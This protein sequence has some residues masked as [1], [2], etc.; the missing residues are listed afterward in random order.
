MLYKN[1]RELPI[2]IFNEISLTND[3]NLLIKENNNNYTEDQLLDK[4]I[5][6]IDEY[7]KLSGSDNAYNEKIS[8]EKNKLKLYILIA[9]RD[10]RD[11]VGIDNE[12]LKLLC[13]DF[14]FRIDKID[15]YINSILKS[16]KTQDELD[17]L[18]ID[19]KNNFEDIL[20]V[21]NENGFNI[22]R[23]IT[24]VSEYLAYIN[25]LK[26]IIKSKEKINKR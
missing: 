8:Y 25:R 15:L 18:N 2:H 24:P 6:I 10:L 9:V 5:D 17:K 22:N 1:C 11:T 3:L 13:K 26:E 23:F 4:W 7:N 16:L 19:K 20:A 21:L 14:S 12:E